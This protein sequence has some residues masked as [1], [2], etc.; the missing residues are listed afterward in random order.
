EGR[1]DARRM[2]GIAQHHIK[3]NDGVEGTAL[4]DPAVD[5]L[6]Q[7]ILVGMVIVAERSSAEGAFKRGQSRSD[8]PDFVSLRQ[9]DELLIASDHRFGAWERL[10]RREVGSRPGDVVD[11]HEHYSR[12]LVRLGEYVPLQSGC[13]VHTHLVLK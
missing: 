5:F 4:P 10:I 12:L 7:R 3:I 11:A 6:T 8:E 1:I 9:R 13:D 2:V